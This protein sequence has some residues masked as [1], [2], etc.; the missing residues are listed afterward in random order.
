MKRFHHAI[1]ITLLVLAC[2]IL[3][4]DTVRDSG[5]YPRIILIAVLTLFCLIA[6]RRFAKRLGV[7]P[8]PGQDFIAVTSRM[9]SSTDE[10]KAIGYI[11]SKL[12][13]TRS[14]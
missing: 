8:I 5:L 2:L 12:L 7:A 3:G 4:V 13:G 10:L 9:M 6:Q 14:S 1:S 11:C